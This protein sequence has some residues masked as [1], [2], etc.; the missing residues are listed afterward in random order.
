M[1]DCISTVPEVHTILTE[2]THNIVRYKDYDKQFIIRPEDTPYLQSI[3]TILLDTKTMINS[4]SSILTVPEVHTILTE[5]THNNVSYKKV[6]ENRKTMNR[7]LRN[8][9]SNPA[10]KTISQRLLQ[11]VYQQYLGYTPR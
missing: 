7:N 11:T 10:L 6:I 1:T 2:S 5:S 9:K 8:Q 4:I 3:L